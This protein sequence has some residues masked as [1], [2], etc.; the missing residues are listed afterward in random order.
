M[1]LNIGYA[2]SSIILIGLFLIS[3]VSQL[4]SKKYHPLLY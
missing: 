3:L 4:V 1:T 2:A